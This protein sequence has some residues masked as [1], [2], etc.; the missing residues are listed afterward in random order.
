MNFFLKSQI[1]EKL[2]KFVK[3]KREKVKKR[4]TFETNRFFLKIV[5]HQ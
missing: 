2:L 5:N 1:T 4:K 3:E